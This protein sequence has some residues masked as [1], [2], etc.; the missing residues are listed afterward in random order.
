MDRRNDGS[1]HAMFRKG[2]MTLLLCSLIT[3]PVYSVT[4]DMQVAY[5][6]D[7]VSTPTT[8]TN[9]GDGN[10]DVD[11]SPSPDNPSTKPTD[12]SPNPSPTPTVDKSKLATIISKADNINA[13][14]QARYTQSSW[15]AFSSAYSAA[16]A[17]NSKTDATQT[18]VDT[19]VSALNTAIN[20]LTVQTWTVTV[21][22]NLSSKAPS[23]MKVE[24]GNYF[25]FVPDAVMNYKFSGFF[26]DSAFKTPMPTSYP[27]TKD[28]SVYALYAKTQTETTK[29]WTVTFHYNHAGDDRTSKVVVDDGSAIGRSN[30]V[31]WSPPSGYELNGWNTDPNGNGSSIDFDKYKVS[32]NLDL[33]AQWKKT[34]EKKSVFFDDS[35]EGKK[36]AQDKKAKASHDAV[37]AVV[38]SNAVKLGAFFA[39]VAVLGSI[40]VNLNELYY[41]YEI[42][43]IYSE[44]N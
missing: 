40:A 32:Q 44:D 18:E 6:D 21:Y 11:P 38:S 23:T 34:D 17:T 12:P 26:L 29:Q 24:S 42:N 31:S 25:V 2:V 13:K 43:K 19:A 3:I 37:M 33:Y 8:G 7:P 15:A 5:A 36:Q 16:T 14:G 41:A 30:V 27:I 28:T 10:T 22:Y 20:G 1:I 4:T 9:T 35:P 39:L